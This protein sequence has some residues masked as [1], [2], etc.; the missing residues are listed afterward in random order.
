[1]SDKHNPGSRE[2]IEAGCTCPRM[3]NINGKGVLIDGQICFWYNPECPY[4][5]IKTDEPKENNCDK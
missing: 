1:M 3:D 5:T 4:H 2:A